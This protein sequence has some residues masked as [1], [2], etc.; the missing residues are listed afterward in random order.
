MNKLIVALIAGLIFASNTIANENDGVI[1]MLIAAK[2]TGMCGTFKQIS[3]FQE[4][5][6][7]PGSDE[8][9][10]RFLNTEAA[11]LG[12]TLPQ[13]PDE[14]QAEVKIYVDMMD[15]LENPQPE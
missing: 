14:C 1:D 11:R 12:K 8:F 9:V 2:A 10:V 3:I 6:Q 15:M 7:M 4:S 5:T 13:F